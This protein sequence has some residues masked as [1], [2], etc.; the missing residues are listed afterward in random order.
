MVEL[1]V[2]VGVTLCT[3]DVNV[4]TWDQIKHH[5]M[6]VLKTVFF[7]LCECCLLCDCLCCLLLKCADF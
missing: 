7:V 3:A 4:T 2:G 5:A 1:F 6:S